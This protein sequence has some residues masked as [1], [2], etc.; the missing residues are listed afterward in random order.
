LILCDLAGSW[1][2]CVDDN[3]ARARR[4]RAFDRP[5]IVDG[6]IAITEHAQVAARGID[7]F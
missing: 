3:D 1:Q 2:F 6:Q 7:Y 5:E 4:E